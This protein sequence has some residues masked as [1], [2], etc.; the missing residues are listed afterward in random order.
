[1][2]IIKDY[3]NREKIDTINFSET[4]RNMF[5]A[6][7]TDKY[8]KYCPKCNQCFEFD[9]VATKSYKNARQIYHYYNDFPS[10]GKERKIC[11]KCL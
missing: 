4:T 3:M 10:Y 5:D 9:L 6:K 11:P 7:R 8:V 1:M 2:S